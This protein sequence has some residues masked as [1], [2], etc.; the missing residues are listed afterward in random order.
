M[1]IF[2]VESVRVC[3]ALSLAVIFLFMSR[4]CQRVMKEIEILL[5]RFFTQFA[6]RLSRSS[7]LLTSDY[8]SR[9]EFHAIDERSQLT[10][11]SLVV[12]FLSISLTRLNVD[13]ALTFEIADSHCEAVELS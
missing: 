2:H 4:K 6:L 1:F 3:S 10:S 13:I 11:E 8:F 7:L 5:F 9:S 12:Y